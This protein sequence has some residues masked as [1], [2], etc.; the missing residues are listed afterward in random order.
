M[1]KLS[2]RPYLQTDWYIDVFDFLTPIQLL[3]SIPHP[4]PRPVFWRKTKEMEVTL[5]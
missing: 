2:N 3:Y 5:S 1:K 4:P